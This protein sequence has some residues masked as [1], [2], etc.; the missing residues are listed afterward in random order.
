MA[1][2]RMEMLGVR[3]RK[4]TALTV[5]IEIVTLIGKGR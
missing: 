1:V 2:K 3:V 4:M 5:K